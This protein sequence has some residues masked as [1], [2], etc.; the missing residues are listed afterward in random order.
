[1]NFKKVMA[2]VSS[3]LM[4][5]SLL[6]S[7]PIEN[8]K[9]EAAT[10]KGDLN[11][12]G[13]LNLVDLVKSRKFMLGNETVSNI[14]NADMNSD[15]SF[16]LLDVVL[17]KKEL[18]KPTAST[19]V[20]KINEICPANSKSI[21]DKDGE[22]SD[23]I[24]LYN[25]SNSPVNLMG[26]GLSDSDTKPFK[27]TLPDVTIQPK[28]YLIVFASGKNV[29][30]NGEIHTSFKLSADGETVVLTAPSSILEDSLTF[31]YL[32]DDITMSRY[33]DGSNTLKTTMATPGLSNNN[34]TQVSVVKP[35][36]FSQESG[37]YAT[38]FNLNI[39]VPEGTTVYYTTDS[40]TPTV[41]SSKYLSN[42][43]Q[44][45]N[46]DNKPNVFSIIENTSVY[47]TWKPKENVAKLNVIKA[48]AVDAAGNPSKVI[49]KS[50]VVNPQIAQKYNGLPIVSVSTDSDNLFGYENGIF[51][52]GAIYGNKTTTG[53]A[54][55]G[56][57]GAQDDGSTPCNYNQRGSEWEREAHIDIIES[58]GSLLLSQDCGI[59]TMG[60][61]SRA[62]LQKSIRF[63][64]RTE[65]EKGK[66]KADLIP[67]LT[68][69]A[70]P[71]V[72]LTEFDTFLLRNGGNANERMQFKDSWVQ[73]L[74]RDRNFPTQGARPCIAF[75]NGEYWGI[76]AMQEDYTDEYI[77]TNYNIPADDAIIVKVGNLDEGTEE[78][79]P[80][81]ENLI[82][83]ATNNDLTNDANYTKVC[84]MIDEQNFIDY[85]CTQIFIA[86]G[87][88]PT[89]NYR[90][91]RS[92]TVTDKPFQDGKWR[93]MLYDLEF[94]MD[95]YK[96]G[97]NY[98]EDTLTKA[99]SASSMW[100]GP[101]TG[102][103]KHTVLF[104]K[105]IK[106][107]TFKQKFVT[108]FMDMINVNFET[109]R[110][111]KMLDDYAQL[112]SPLL[113]DY[114]NR[115]GPEFVFEEYDSVSQFFGTQVDGVK[116]FMTN[117][118]SFI[119]S[120]L[121][122]KLALKGNVV[123]VNVSVN[124]ATK[125]DIVVNTTKPNLSNGSFKGKYFTDYPITLKANPK[126]GARFTGWS[127]GQT[128]ETIT[129]TLSGVMSI[130]AN[131]E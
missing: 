121:K 59:R 107:S 51:V 89:N 60:G 127:N 79:Q 17:M 111:F 69:D 26:Y 39:S 48:V 109:G 77:A 98:Q 64:A 58:D 83:F 22:D 23:W 95:L 82:N 42:G 131:F 34:A 65:Y 78:D 80:L 96:D 104:G 93:W 6:F 19:G 36:E 47:S 117:R 30:E 38:S 44:I 10:V 52:K 5:N 61:W 113:N 103:D 73:D 57:G 8:K 88:W 76:Y 85:Y 100:G 25:S 94:S 92:R 90:I 101:S 128:S 125:G 12:D 29:V 66:F 67:G 3:I 81:Y 55:G 108:T 106:N 2:A 4:V 1:M 21:K 63:Y 126:N 114:Y 37:L 62:Y 72:S 118:I 49:T 123:D 27:W 53:P 45:Q 129:I 124:D 102:T 71:E 32:I 112:Y 116:Y 13:V 31:N 54:V 46:V 74:V 50:Y 9:V 40:S 68:Q 28:S 7:L 122:Q 56:W 11:D 18:L 130:Q 97:Q 110:A 35:P 41:N 75:V 84:D 120:L 105:L 24:E 15:G 43:I 70:Y 16:N 14:L 33:P 99:M 91:W 87:D 86:N 119:P 115:F 20:I